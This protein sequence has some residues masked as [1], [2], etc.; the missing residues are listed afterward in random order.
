MRRFLK[1]TGLVALVLVSGSIIA[2][3]VS[4][5][6]IAAVGCPGCYGFEKIDRRLFVGR[7]MGAEDRRKLRLDLA[8]AHDAVAD[9]LGPTEARPFIFA[10]SKDVCDRRIGGRGDAGARAEVHSTP[11]FSVVRFGP[12]GINQTILTHELAHITMHEIVGPY[13]V[14]DGCFPAWL[15]EGVAVIVSNDDRYLRPGTTARERC[16]E[17]PDGLLPADPFKWRPA[18]GQDNALYARAACKA[19][20]WLEA[21]GGMEGL[22]DA[23][24]RTAR[25]GMPVTQR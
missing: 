22:L 14:M 9:T 10:C 2:F 20:H 5:P 23:L 17:E 6:S 4:F 25:T 15:N 24:S 3:I 13:A 8:A 7:D 21:N 1:W 19:L 18:A 12:R 11:W 16:M